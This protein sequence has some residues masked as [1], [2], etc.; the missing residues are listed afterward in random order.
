VTHEGCHGQLIMVFFSKIDRMGVLYHGWYNTGA[1]R[2]FGRN[3][4]KKVA[5]S[6]KSM[7]SRSDK[8]AWLIIIFESGIFKSIPHLRMDARWWLIESHG[9]VKNVVLP[10]S[11]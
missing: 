2:F 11:C 10:F 3:S 5:V 6:V 4:A 8:N 9:D 1:A 7:R